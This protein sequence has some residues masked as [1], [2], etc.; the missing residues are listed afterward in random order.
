MRDIKIYL[1]TNTTRLQSLVHVMAAACLFLKATELSLNLSY[2]LF[3]YYFYV[4][5]GLL[6][7]A[8]ALFQVANRFTYHY[9]APILNILAGVVLTVGSLVKFTVVENTVKFTGDTIAYYLLNFSMGLFFIATGLFEDRIRKVPYMAF[10]RHKIYGRQSWMATFTF[11]WHEIADVNFRSSRIK[12]TTHA[13]QVYRFRVAR[14]S[15][16]GIMYKSAKYFCQQL[17]L[18]GQEENQEPKAS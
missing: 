14:Q 8:A 5:F 10:N 15:A 4:G 17:F 16:G 7:T 13:G 12:I 6:L 1:H 9:L 18:R 3:W 11:A 2:Y